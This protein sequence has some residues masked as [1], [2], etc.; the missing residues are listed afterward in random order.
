MTFNKEEYREY[1]HYMGV[2][3]LNDE[4]QKP[5]AREM[6][7][8]IYLTLMRNSISVNREL[9][10]TFISDRSKQ[11]QIAGPCL[12]NNLSVITVKWTEK[13]TR[14]SKVVTIVKL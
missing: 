10:H 6:R 14:K 7:K 11:W 12:R 13:Q 8:K 1:L 5:S 2:F 3:C 9:K 4:G